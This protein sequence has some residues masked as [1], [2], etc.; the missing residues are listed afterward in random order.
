MEF[1][2]DIEMFAFMEA[3]FYA[4]ALSDILDEMGFRECAVSPHAMIRP[5]FPDAVCAGRVRTLL[6]APAR[7]GTDDPYRLAI[8]V[9]DSL[10]PGEVCV[11]SSDAPI[12]T[13]IMGE[14]SAMAMAKRGGRGCIVDGYT[15]DARKIV[16]RGFPV[17]ARGVSPIDTTD[18]VRVVEYDCPVIL[19]GRR[20]L[21]GQI[22]F[23]DLD[24]IVLI[25]GE[26]EREVIGEAAKRVETETEIRTH[27][28]EG[29]SMRDMW[30]RYRVL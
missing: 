24:G 14:L 30:D 16:R 18:R 15:R 9:I 12:E 3:H 25:P 4:E 20:V 5:L 17:F 8:E 29:A 23:A 6:N 1:T 11:A 26:V 10:K 2:S 21:P 28:S 13:G 7:T 27:L 19:G 22:V